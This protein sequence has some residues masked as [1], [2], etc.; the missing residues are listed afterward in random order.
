[1]KRS[2]LWAALALSTCTATPALAQTVSGCG[3]AAIP[4][5]DVG[6]KSKLTVQAD[7]FGKAKTLA[8]DAE[9]LRRERL[10]VIANV[11]GTPANPTPSTAPIT[12][13]SAPYFTTPLVVRSVTMGCEVSLSP[14]KK[15]QFLGSFTISRTGA[16]AA[17][18][19]LASCGGSS[20]EP[21][22]GGTV[23]PVGSP[24]I[25]IPQPSPTPTATPIPAG[26]QI[27]VSAVPV[28]YYGTERIWA[29]LA[30]RASEWTGVVGGSNDQGNPKVA[31][32]II[33]MAPNAV[34]HGQSTRVT[35]TW[36]G[37]GK[38]YIAG[39]ETAYGDHT[40]ST[41][42]TPVGPPGKH[43]ALWID[44]TESDGTFR[45]LDCREPGVVANGRLDQRYVDDM[46]LYSVVRFLD[47]STANSNLPITWATRSLPNQ[48][49]AT[50][51]TGDQPIEDQIEIA[52]AMGADAWFTI[53]WNA[54]DAYVRGMATLIRDTLKGKAYFETGNEV[55]NWMFPV[56]TQALNEGLARNLSP[57]KWDNTMLRYAEKTVEQNKILTDVFK[58]QSTRLV[59]V[60]S[61]QSG[62]APGIDQFLAFRDT[63][64][65][66][67]AIADAPYFGVDELNV[68]KPIGETQA[69]LFA[70]LE[71]ARLASIRATTAVADAA[72]RHGKLSMIYEGGQSNVSTDVNAAVNEEMQRSPLMEAAYGRYLVDLRKVH[73]G[74]LMLYNSTG[75]TSRYG[76]WGQHEYTGQ[77]LADA[78]KRRAIITAVG[79]R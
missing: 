79:Q 40:V 18:A 55:W 12:G 58:A 15:A 28:V 51:W 62:N 68:D 30:Y 63:A 3:T 14:A 32:R 33:L 19:L 73:T 39:T 67:D 52:N 49:I 31:G 1:M 64:Q 77:P 2:I 57:N 8:S 5:A 53:P 16:L 61:F 44:L 70:R 47:W 50:T 22:S 76:S 41:T 20:G 45:D 42:W 65:W 48:Q 4:K 24:S 69:Q 13:S 37:A 71:T 66:I 38:I 10:K 27:G 56:T 36:R 29:N 46:R 21:T 75:P 25:P 78:P 7:C 54:D 60:A 17:A 74:P 43:G 26:A 34:L 59:R 9:T 35:C 23:V 72:K 11:P 6:N